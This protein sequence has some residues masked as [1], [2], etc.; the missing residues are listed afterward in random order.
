M[1]PLIKWG[2]YKSFE[3]PYVHGTRKFSLP[4][5]P[6]PEHKILGVV[7][8]TEG[9]SMDGVNMYDTCIVSCGL[10]Q[11][12]EARYFLTSKMLSYMASRDPSV[13]G[14][15]KPAMDLTGSE[16]AEIKPGT[17]R[18][19]YRDGRPVNRRDL[20]AALFLGGAT[21]A[22][23]AWN[24][25]AKEVAKLWCRCFNET[26][27]QDSTFDLQVAY[28]AA[29]LRSFSLASARNTLFSEDLPDEG[30][31]GTVRA[32]FLSFAANNPTIAAKQLAIAV[33]G[34]RAKK[35]SRDWVIACLK[36][37]TF[38]PNIAIYPGRYNKIRVPLERYYGV[39]LPDFQQELREWRESQPQQAPDEPNLE[40]LEGIQEVLIAAGY[41]LGPKGADGIWGKKTKAAVIAFQED[42]GLVTDAIVGPKTR[43]ALLARW[44]SLH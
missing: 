18:F 35:W 3:G 13:L 37:M 23:G 6:T 29:R 33:E 20:Q 5:N 14:P 15:L 36:Q 25:E 32:A 2:S 4:S 24:D 34:T 11:W 8:S 21:G 22:K 40:E 17:W 39:D 41:D 38:G 16:F 28:T 42:S 26:F 1:L 27:A 43:A 31:V 7:T 10:I 9:G 19:R 44:R 30:L 12:C